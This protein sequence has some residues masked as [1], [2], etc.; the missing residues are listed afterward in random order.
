MAGIPP[1]AAPIPPPSDNTGLRRAAA[2]IAI[3]LL[4]HIALA[5]YMRPSYQPVNDFAVDL[6]ITTMSRLPP[7]PQ[8]PAEPAPP[9]KEEPVKPS[10]KKAAVPK[11]AAAEAPIAA[12]EK[13]TDTGVEKPSEEQDTDT[14]E[15]GGICMHNLFAFEDTEP[16]WLLYVAAS[17][18]R[19][20]AYEKELDNTFNSF[21]LGRR[22]A[23]M[24][25]MNLTRDVESLLV[26]ASD[27][28]DWRTFQITLSYDFGEETLMARI[29][30]KQK[31]AQSFTWNK[32]DDGFEA[33]IPGQFRWELI[34]SGRVMSIAYEPEQKVVEIPDN[35]F[36]DA[37]AATDT[38]GIKETVD[39]KDTET[40][41]PVAGT[42]QAGSASQAAS[43]EKPSNR[44]RQIE[45]LAL[46]Q[47]KTGGKKSVETLTDIATGLMAPNADGHWPVAVLTT[48]D[49]RA[50]GLGARLGKRMGF[51]VASVRGYFTD[52]VRLEGYLRF[53]K[54]PDKVAALAE[55]WRQDAE[56]FAQDPFMAMAGVSSLL[57]NLTL[58]TDGSTLHFSLELKPSQVL[59]TLL[60][61]QLQGKALE[62][63]LMSN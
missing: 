40:S 21:E 14:N 6:E 47:K 31:Q 38:A 23:D 18:F 53:S 26:S 8:K 57:K 34:G 54:D 41:S 20:S 17:A 45:C 22:L 56:R 50:V 12:V 5:L 3:S 4:I 28:F 59:S 27:I 43:K 30:D 48:S 13:D 51:E 36:A 24:T 16:A 11:A 35:P 10:P 44:P 61:L 37:K 63:Q 42:D 9:P 55:G 19:G 25:G 2:A 46:S 32:T 39:P 7:K 1:N 15:G 49:P 58:T 52:P 29:K 33:A 60:F 62:R